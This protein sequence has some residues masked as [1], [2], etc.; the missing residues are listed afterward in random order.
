MEVQNDLGVTI[1][2]PKWYRLTIVVP[3]DI[4]QLVPL[5]TPRKTLMLKELKGR[6]NIRQ[7]SKQEIYI[8][9][10]HFYLIWN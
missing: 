10:T 4:K 1:H 5:K 6:L 8:A 7:F 2:W 3:D 9:N